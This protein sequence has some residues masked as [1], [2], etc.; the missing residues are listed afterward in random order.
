MKTSTA[1]A[2]SFDSRFR[3]SVVETTRWLAHKESAGQ[4]E[5]PDGALRRHGRR[6]ERPSGDEI[7]GP[8]VERITR[9]HLSPTV[10]H[11][12]IGSDL[13]AP[14]D[15]ESASASAGVDQCHREV[16][17][18]PCQEETREARA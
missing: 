14:L 2:E 18:E 7:V 12:C 13:V 17:P 16:R 1:Q 15:E 6:T 5:K 3:P 10:N 9:H 8:V 4:P 11:L